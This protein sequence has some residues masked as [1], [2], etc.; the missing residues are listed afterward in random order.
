MPKKT[1]KKITKDAIKTAYS[2]KNALQKFPNSLSFNRLNFSNF[3]YVQFDGI[4]VAYT[5]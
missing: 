5:K 1:I 2:T 4:G 3:S